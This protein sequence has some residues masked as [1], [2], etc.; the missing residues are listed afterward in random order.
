MTSQMRDR[1][2]D[3][4]PPRASSL[5]RHVLER[6]SRRILLTGEP[7]IGKSTA[8]DAAR[9][10]FRAAGTTV[11]WASPSFAERHTAHSVLR[12]LLSDV[13]WD[14]L[15]E[16]SA[17]DRAILRTAIGG[18][19]PVADVP[20]LGTAIALEGIL[21]ALSARAPV[22]LLIDDL[23][24]SDPESSAGIERAFRR[25]A[26]PRVGLVATSR[27]YGTRSRDAPDLTFQPSDVHVLE[28]LTVEE[29]ER[30]IRP[31]WPSTLTRAQVVALHEH[32]GGNPMWAR[33]LIGRGVLDDLGAISVGTLPA[34]LPLTVAVAERLRA[35]G[36]AADV[37]SIVALLGRPD[38]S[39]LGEVLRFGAVPRA[40]IDQAEAAGFLVVSTQGVHTRHPL[41]A[42]AAAARLAPARRR[43]LHAF[44]ARAVD[45][46]VLRAQHLQQSAPP[47]PDESI[48]EALTLAAVLMRQRGARLRSAHFDAQAVERTDP[49]APNRQ[50]RLLNQ[51]QQLFSAGDEEACLAVLSRVA[52]DRLDARQYDAHVALSTG[53]L[54]AGS[55]PGAAR[56]WLAARP[57]EA[58]AD[59]AR[60][61]I[62]GANTLAVA[63]MT[64]S[65][66][67]RSAA[68]AMTE[69][70]AV[71]APNAVHR[72]LRARARTRLEAGS[73]L[74][75]TVVAEMD[76][77]QAVQ[78]VVSLDDTGLATTAHLAHLV[79]DVDASRRAL[80]GLV[81]WAQREGKEGVA[82]TFLAHAAL[83]EVV[84]GD[85]PAARAFMELADHDPTSPVL[86]PAVQLTAGLLLIADGRH[87]V[88]ARTVDEWRHR[89][90]GEADELTLSAVAGASA[91]AQGRWQHAVE[92]LRA[93]AE[94]ADSLELVELGSRLRV[95]LPLAEALV[96]AGENDEAARRLDRVRA[97]LEDR[98]RPI[99][100][101]DLHRLTSLQLAAGGDLGGALAQATT[102][103]ELS[104]AH[105]RPADVARALLQ[106]ARVQH[107]LRK[108]ALARSDL[109]AAG[110]A[111]LEAGVVPVRAEV[112]AARSPSSMTRSA[113]ELTTAES[114]V[115]ACLR[116]GQSNREIAAELFV[117]VRT[118]ESH[119]AAILRKTGA[120]SRAKLISRH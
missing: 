50:E 74:D 40:A 116:A 83:V 76:R 55:T 112:D 97:F 45:D 68:A 11:L 34:P 67:A 90:G 14:S 71:D 84:G 28:G 4:E 102:A 56:T 88:L 82:R 79:D 21:G 22:V 54:D 57:A 29:L 66:R 41:H 86:P 26:S 108:V 70:A 115:L 25:V 36:P 13:D 17:E 114:R 107:R 98:D 60:R 85:V 89:G 110:E 8:L 61:A 81:E 105:H 42:S 47:G 95:D 51:A 103:V 78:I 119:V 53:S 106:R 2:A 32:T 33:E 20:P 62:L 43:E 96:R 92:H 80:V 63:T 16:L 120:T 87:E 91:L 104:T 9:T 5:V 18:H 12:D 65:G 7:G 44:I 31:L 113:T 3:V 58:A 111:A 77:L 73:G 48:A 1:L 100:Q 35:L 38:L 30:L 64:V 117:S 118:V 101:I 109:Q 24:W 72:A 99:S 37:V 27:E 94:L 19:Q 46:P 39:L 23:Q 49:R 52:E 59:P 69:L 93:A 10:W 75:L 15:M 6:D